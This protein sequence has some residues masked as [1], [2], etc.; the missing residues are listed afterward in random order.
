[1]ATIGTRIYTWLRGQEVG[2]DE[3]GNR[4]FE[5]KYRPK[6]RRRKRWAIYKGMDEASKVPGHWHG[7]LH[8]TLEK[9]PKDNQRHYE[10]Q[11][12][13]LPNVTGTQMAYVPEGHLR[14]GGKRYKVSS[15]YEPWKP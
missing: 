7:W 5:E 10:W 13:H 12:P 9:A 2:K 1:M 3:F 14:K 4:Y 8:Y 6:H 15:D 11:K